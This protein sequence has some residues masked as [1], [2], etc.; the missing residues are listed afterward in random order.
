M[1]K[2]KAYVVSPKFAFVPDPDD[3]RRWVRIH[4]CAVF[5]PCVEGRWHTGT[6]RG[7][8]AKEGEPCRNEDGSVSLMMCHHRSHKWWEEKFNF[9]FDTEI[10]YGT[11]HPGRED[12][13]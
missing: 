6:R 10:S 3:P 11:V 2:Q 4:P 12:R 13:Q 7:C 9:Q 5:F 8:G 1:R